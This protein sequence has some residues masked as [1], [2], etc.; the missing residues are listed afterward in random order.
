MRAFWAR[1]AAVGMAGS[2]ALLFV[3]VGAV[4]PASAKARVYGNN[5]TVGSLR[6]SVYSQMCDHDGPLHTRLVVKNN[7]TSP[8]TIQVNDTFAHA[9]YDPPGPIAPG[10]RMLIH[11]ISS[12]ITPEHTV[13]IASDGESKTMTVP[14][15][16]C[17][18]VTSSTSTSSTSSSSSS[19]ST[20]S[21]T[22]T[23]TSSTINTLPSDPGDPGGPTVAGAGVVAVGASVTG[24]GTGPT[25]SASTGTLPFTGTDI[26]LF[27][28]LGNLLVLIGFGLLYLSHRSPRAAAFFKRLRPSATP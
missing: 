5:A 25:V 24:G 20:T 27:A 19:T 21:T 22:K 16:P 10:D 14:K 15:S 6:V 26:R 2:L 7:G 17:P 8:K 18:P 3:T 13:V 12:K 11:L 28:V 9:G 1:L 23:S 4:T